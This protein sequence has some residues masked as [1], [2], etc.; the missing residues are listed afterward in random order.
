MTATE[1][2]IAGTCDARFDGVRTAFRENFDTR[3]DVG[4]S[5][6][7]TID[8]EPVVDLWGGWADGARKRAWQR[9]TI[10]N[11]YSATKGVLATCM[12]MLVDRGLIDLDAPVA[13][14]WPEFAAA[15]KATLPVRYL[16]SHQA[17]LP[18]VRRPVPDEAVYEWDTMVHALE[19]QEPW[20]AP[21]TNQGYHAATFGWLNGEVLRRVTG[22]M[23]SAFAR[24]QIVEPLGVEFAIAFGPELDDRVAEMLVPV[25]SGAGDGPS[26]AAWLR[27]PESLAGKT[28]GNP[29]RPPAVANTRRWR[30]AEIPSSNGHVNAR[31]LA[32][33]YSALAR[34][35]ELDGVRLLSAEAI[36][37]AAAQQVRSTD[38]VLGIVTSRSLGYM[39][40]IAEQGDPR[41]AGAFG[42]G[43]MGGSIGFA[44]PAHR[45][46]FGYAMNQMGGVVD[47]R[48]RVLAEAAYA[49]LA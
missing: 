6:A 23:F 25:P 34:G 11:V 40:P 12:H 30:A 38:A 41:G 19:A 8:G 42:H 29:P 26:L 45:M 5:V 27:D 16:L 20:W 14:Y 49:A 39:L 22:Q 46:G 15:G 31:G 24:E 13:T 2:P 4:A 47:T 36:V 10:V 21:G 48:W 35:G 3:G 9:D 32:R 18:A 43:G 37:R 7:I 1:I 28:F 17:G 33:L 44:D